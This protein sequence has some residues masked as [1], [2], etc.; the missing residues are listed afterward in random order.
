MKIHCISL[1]KDQE[2]DRFPESLMKGEISRNSVWPSG[3]EQIYRNSSSSSKFL[4]FN[5]SPFN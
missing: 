2:K 5:F 1:I 4:N 3:E